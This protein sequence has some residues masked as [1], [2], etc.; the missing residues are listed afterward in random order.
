[1]CDRR[2]VR[3]QDY[4]LCDKV[5]SDYVSEGIYLKFSPGQHW[6]WLPT[7]TWDETTVFISWDSHANG[8]PGI[9]LARQFNG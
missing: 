2:S 5:H 1:M 3:L 6:Y 7:Q 4:A 9:T 8:K